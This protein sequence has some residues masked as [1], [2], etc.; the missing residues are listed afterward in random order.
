M[1]SLPAAAG[2]GGVVLEVA[3]E[4]QANVTAGD[5][6]A[7]A[8]EVAFPDAYI[9]LRHQ[10]GLHAAIGQRD[11]ACHEPDDVLG[12]QLH[13]LFGQRH[14]DRQLIR[15]AELHA[16]L[17]QGLVLGFVSAVVAD[18]A[19]AGGVHDLVGD[20]LLFVEAV[21]QALERVGRV[22]A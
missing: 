22:V 7:V 20:Q 16:G 13:L 8:L 3:G 6:G 15:L 2:D 9:G 11:V 10:H 14:A 12:E 5:Q 4:V 21:T 17:H 18:E 19:L 1:R